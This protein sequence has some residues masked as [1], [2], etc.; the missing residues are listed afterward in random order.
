M[1]RLYQSKVFDQPLFSHTLE[2]FALLRHLLFYGLKTGT[3]FS[4][5][6]T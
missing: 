1:K 4:C 2:I 5:N 3:N 6:V